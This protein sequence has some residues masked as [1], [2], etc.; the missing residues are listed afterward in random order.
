MADLQSAALPTQRDVMQR[1]MST[2]SPDL[3]EVCSDDPDLAK[4]VAAWPDLPEG[5][6]QA[7][8]ALVNAVRPALGG[9]K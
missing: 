8:L 1:V 7:V 3:L 5:V 2:A 6:R 9:T 4:V